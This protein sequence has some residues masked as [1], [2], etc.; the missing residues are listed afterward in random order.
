MS[1]SS[2]RTFIKSA[3]ATTGIGALAGCTSLGGGG[4]GTPTLG[5]RFVVAPDNSNSL[6]AISDIQDQLDGYGSDYE[7]ESSQD[8]ATTDSINALAAGEADIADLSATSFASTVVNEPVEGGIMAIASDYYDAYPDYYAQ[9]VYAAPDSGIESIEDLEGQQ[10]GVNALGTGVH[11]LFIKALR[12]VGL[13]ADDVEFVEQPFPTFV[14]ALNEGT[15]DTGMFPSLFAVEA[16]AEG[17]NTVFSSHDIVEDPYSF[18]FPVVAQDTLDENESAVQSWVE[19]YAAA[20]E[21]ARNN[22]S[23]VVSMIS[24][25]FDISEDLIDPYWLTQDDYYKEDLNLDTDA[26]QTVVDD[27]VEF[28][29]VDEEFDV[30][31][32][33]DNGYLP[34]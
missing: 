32:Y 10:L 9:T 16:R 17:F 19:D 4:G 7:L 13:S 20:M 29:M 1:F 22:R 21:Y 6:M 24:E 25:H 26:L 2:R 23:D 14:S 28:G 3:I 30:A 8:S 27:Y 5:M 18:A 34:D 15:M 11:A 31:N 33:V 12:S